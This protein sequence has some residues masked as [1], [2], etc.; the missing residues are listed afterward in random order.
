MNVGSLCTRKVATVPRETSVA[1]AAKL[2]RRR[3]VGDVVVT[4]AVRS[5]TVPVGIITD[6][7]IVISVIALELDPNVFTVGDMLL[8]PAVTCYEFDDVTTCLNS[9]RENAI[10]RMPVVDKKGALIGII[11][12]DDL[13]RFLSSQ[14]TAVSKLITREQSVE[15]K[16]RV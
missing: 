8:R 6:R 2:M 14:L 10:R 4:G 15:R 12:I 7:D 13:I 5:K 9:M 3:H 11:C 1:E 16:T